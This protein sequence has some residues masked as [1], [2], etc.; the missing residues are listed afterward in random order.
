MVKRGRSSEDTARR[1]QR[2]RVEKEGHYQWR[3]GACIDRR[4]EIIKLL[5]EGTFAKVLLCEDRKVKEEVAVKVV[6]NVKRYCDGAEIE[7]KMLRD[8]EEA[9]VK[10][11][12]AFPPLLDHFVERGHYCM[13]FP[14]YGPSIYQV[15]F[16]N[17]HAPYTSEAIHAIA[18]YLL[19]ALSFLHSLRIIHTDIKPEN[20]LF[21]DRHMVKYTNGFMS[22][23]NC[24]IVLVDY[25]SAQYDYE[26]KGPAIQ[27][28]NY[29]A[30]EVMATEGNW[31][32][33]A[34][35]WSVGC[36]LVELLTGEFI[37]NTDNTM[38][39]LAAIEKLT[40]PLPSFLT[41]D[42]SMF[43]SR[44]YVRWPDHTT[45]PAERA[46][47]A[48]LP[49]LSDQCAPLFDRFSQKNE[50]LELISAILN[51]DPIKRLTAKEALRLDFVHVE[52][53]S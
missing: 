37:F 3:K 28:R 53:W 17:D 7:A 9:N 2:R 42:R 8:I 31:S 39:H 36:M 24:E 52:P 26:P 21:K 12:T 47:L 30:P 45:T 20:V 51:P 50:F 4:Y 14:H 25:G 43:D 27:T 11:L 33:P 48:H 41:R 44:G 15:L 13:V 10:R 6:R 38:E 1:S 46:Y 23:L 40:G 35:M 16:R 18:Y 5:G 19:K 32:M 34:D 22:P 49:P 29:R